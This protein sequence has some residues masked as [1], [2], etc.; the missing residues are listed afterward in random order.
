MKDFKISKKL[1]TTF[2]I[3]IV[4]LILISSFSIYGLF[5]TFIK[6]QYFYEGPFQVTNYAMEM[7]RC[8]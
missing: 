8:N 5:R 2:S 7:R 6:Y 4:V 3:V 1:G